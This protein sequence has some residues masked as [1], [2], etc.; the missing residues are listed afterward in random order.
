[1]QDLA[2]SSTKPI[3]VGLAGAG[4]VSTYH[5]RALRSLKHVQ[6]VGVA[7][8]DVARARQLAAHFSIP[9]VYPSLAKMAS[10]QPDVI[11]ILTP[12][13]SH[14]QLTIEAL[15][16]GCHVFV[17]KPMA[18]TAEE[19][20][21]MIAAARMAGRILSVN[22]SARMDPIVL[23]ALDLVR[24]GACGDILAVD[25]F[26]G[27][28]YPPYAGGPVPA[29]Y[30][31]GAYPFQDL[32]VHGLYLL[33]AFL[34][35]IL[36]LDVRYSSSGRE[37]NLLFDE[38]RALAACE[39][40][41][42]QM[43]L[44]WSARPMRNEIVIQGTRGSI[45]VDC[46]LQTC[47]VRKRLPA[48]RFIG[49]VAGALAASASTL[50]SVPWNVLRFATGKLLSSPGIHTSIQAF[51][52]SLGVGAPPPVT[53]DE[54]RRM[55]AWM[56]QVSREAN[57]EKER[58][59]G[60]GAPIP[61]AK[62]LVTGATGFLGRALLQRL[63]Q[64]GEPI[65]VLVRRPSES[66]AHDPLIHQVCGDLGD[67]EA[68]DRAVSGVDLV[69]HVGA[70]MRGGKADFGRG[71][72]WGTRNIVDAC[73]RHGIRKLV[74]V[75]SLTVLDHANHR[76]GEPVTEASPLEP[77]AAARGF[78]TQ[79]KLE[80]EK[81]VLDA[82]HNYDLPA[83]ILR[84]GQIFGAGAEKTAPSGT[85]A[86]AGRWVVIGS[87]KLR[88]PLVYVDDVVDALL[89]AEERN[90]QPG[91]VFHL[92]DPAVVTQNEYLEL[93]RKVPGNALRI[94]RLPRWLLLGA[95]VGVEMLCGLLHRDAPVSRYRL[96]SARPLSPCDC[97][98]AQVNLGWIPRTGARR[99]LNA[100]FEPSRCA[101]PEAVGREALNS[102]R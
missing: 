7:D 92:V 5:A 30:R 98:A 12:P 85:I 87:G 44:S 27:S 1:M 42:G 38:W 33:E 28:D 8:P 15:R 10:A 97:S 61:P 82:V 40:G 29:P 18:E 46:F 55:V 66:L 39:K 59:L 41:T 32:G 23:K 43:Y 99:G 14:C 37:P 96:R 9:A 2:S 53:A 79:S 36:N 91:A 67:P 88:L 94:W 64:R 35:R 25:F 22:H 56:Q 93:C 3:R 84:P 54:G 90:V 75:S 16:M 17:E 77:R 72:V 89:M 24:S 95:S 74:Y 51:Y 65:R 50:V 102:K 101:A 71:T 69:Y 49:L 78:Y 48:P 11:H 86:I 52:D 26:R 47:V 31:V 34:G 19:C 45:H 4:Y 62:I 80:A 73:L 60:A 83:V 100:I 20:D 70:A 81:I 13:S 57:A 68:V 76:R 63:R 58:R 6:I 21:Q